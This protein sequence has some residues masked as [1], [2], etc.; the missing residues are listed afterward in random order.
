VLTTG[1]YLVVALAFPVL[2]RRLPRSATAISALRVRYPDGR[3][4][5]RQVLQAA[6]ELG[7]GTAE[8]LAGSQARTR[9]ASHRP[10]RFATPGCELRDGRPGRQLPSGGAAGPPVAW[11]VSAARRLL[12]RPA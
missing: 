11:P 12:E 2:T 1:I 9:P 5:S 6:T 10:A 8:T 4:L 3:G 7:C